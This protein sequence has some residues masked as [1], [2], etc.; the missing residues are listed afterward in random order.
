MSIK[1]K[2]V[3]N[4]GVQVIGKA[5]STLLGIIVVAAMARYLGQEGYG[6]Y[7]TIIA[8]LQIF[9]I[10]VDFGLSLMTVQMISERPHDPEYNNKIL[11]NVFTLRL[12]S[13][14]FFLGLAPVIALLFP[15]PAIVKLG[16]ALAS[17]SFLFISLNQILVGIFQKNLRMD[18]TSI[19][20]VLGRVM[21]LI[22]VF[23]AI[24]FEKGLMVILVAVVAGSFVNFIINL[25][26]VR[27]FARLRFSFDMNV[28]RKVIE[29]SWPIGI[30]IAF[31]LIYFK[32]DT[33]ILSIFRSQSEVGLYGAPYRVLEIL[34]S[35]PFMFIGVLMPLFA[36]Y[37]TSK[38]IDDYKRLTQEA[39]DFLAI[40][41]WPMILGTVILAEPIMVLVAGPEFAASGTILQILS[42]ATAVI[43]LGTL[44]SHLIVSLGKQRKMI[45][46]YIATAIVALTLYLGLIPYFGM[47]AAAWI[48][49][50]SETMIAAITFT[51]VYVTI[52]WRPSLKISNRALGAALLMSAIILISQIYIPNV[53]ALVIIGAATYTLFLFLF[54]GISK[55]FILEIAAIKKKV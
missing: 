12:F 25:A 5:L 24:H 22:G 34:I 6:N 16:I 28:W 30:S 18:R 26:F 19:A 7:T 44:F 20:E 42:I 13:A 21:L 15:Y 54:R 10:L 36:L 8:F 3:W 32:A 17:L 31:N 37:W 55:K 40:V 48:T 14:I 33:V 49:V 51:V 9:G 38:K 4:T 47:Y 23:T 50:L 1:K 35:F 43:F 46:G 27:R 29:R 2:I 39:F 45:V 52:N 53:I 11:S 41:V